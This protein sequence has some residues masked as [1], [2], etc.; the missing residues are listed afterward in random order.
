[1]GK[2]TKLL[3]SIF[4][5]LIILAII[6]IVFFVAPKVLKQKKEREEAVKVYSSCLTD[7]LNSYLQCES[8]TP[9]GYSPEFIVCRDNQEKC[10]SECK[11]IYQEKLFK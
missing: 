7:C 11:Q 1:M 10:N 5:G 8:M 6:L 9:E 3:I 4:I 2:N